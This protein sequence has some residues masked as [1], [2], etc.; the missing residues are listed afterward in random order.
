MTVIID[1]TNGITPVTV[2]STADLTISGTG[3]RIIG[4]FSN[5]TLANRVLFQTSTTNGQTRVGCLPSGTATISMLE[6]F[7]SSDPSNASQMQLSISTA[8]VALV[9]QKQGTGTYLPMTFYTSGS[10]KLRIAADA[11]GT[12]TFGGTA[13]RIT[14]D[15]SNATITS[16]VAI[17]TN[18]VNGITA[19]PIWP[20]GTAVQTNL[21]LYGKDLD[22][23]PAGYGFM[24][25]GMIGASNEVRIA[26]GLSGTGQLG[27][28][29]FPAITIY[30]SNAERFRVAANGDITDYQRWYVSQSKRRNNCING[31]AYQLYY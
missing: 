16:E 29:A 27:D 18:T 2:G 8:E 3:K 4:D 22:T 19:V 6:A 5:A 14:G 11:T 9:S 13:P 15:F 31:R 20:N 30:T 17:K 1:G 26:G 21:R 24:N 23:A 10:E 28:S 7:N 12:Y 25:L